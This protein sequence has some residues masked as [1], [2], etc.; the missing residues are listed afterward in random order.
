MSVRDA[1]LALLSQSASYGYQLK[2]EFERRTGS[3]W[4]VN[5]GQIYQTLDRLERGGLV[6]HLGVDEE[7][8]QLFVATDAGRVSA[9]QW[10]SQ[11]LARPD[12]PRND[13]AM[14]IAL[15]ATLDG[16]DVYDVI[17]TQRLAVIAHLQELTR[18]KAAVTDPDSPEELAWQ[19]SVDAEIFRAE[20]EARWLDHT[21]SRLRRLRERG[22]E[23][24]QPILTTAPRGRPARPSTTTGIAPTT[25]ARS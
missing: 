6:E 16:V 10:F 15:A 19:L 20:S 21:E 8:H 5:V 14:K 25:D 11:P 7:G 22:I 24:V 3:T 4:V 13:L 12:A 17:Q 1:V 18:S 23:L 2:L 9:R